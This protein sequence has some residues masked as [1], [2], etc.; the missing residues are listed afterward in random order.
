MNCPSCGAANPDD[1]QACSACGAAASV[2]ALGPGFLLASRY[3][4]LKV[5]GRGGMGMVYQARDRLLDE[6]VAIKVLRPDAA[7]TPE[8]ARRFRA[9]IK[10]ARSVSHKNVGRIHEY[11][12]DRGIRYISMAFVDGVD[13]KQVLR[14]RGPLPPAEAF[15][16]LLRVADALQ[17]I[18][19]EGIIHRDLKA[20]NVML[21]RRGVV[22]LMDFGIAKQHDDE[23][24]S[25]TATGQIIGTPEYMSPEQVQ[26]L[27]LDCRSDVYSLGVVAFELF[28]G[29]T[30]FRADTPLGTVLK[31]LNE[32]PPLE[33]EQAARLPPAL[34]PV[35][36][37]ALAKKR[38]DR[39]SSAREMAQALEEA[40]AL[41]TDT[42]HR[43]AKT[44]KGPYFPGQGETL[45]P[46]LDQG[47]KAPTGERAAHAEAT[48]LL[49]GPSR[50]RRRA[51]LAGG[52]GA[53]LV[54]ATWALLRPT[55][56]AATAPA[57]PVVSSPAPPSPLPP[58]PS[59]AA[60]PAPSVALDPPPGG[61]PRVAVRPEPTPVHPVGGA[62]AAPP[63]VDPG[64]ASPPAG[65]ARVDRLLAEA[66]RAL[67]AESFD[68]A[69]ARY[70]EVLAVDARN[71]VARMGRTAAVSA[72]VARA[73]AR[74]PAVRS[75]VAEKTRAESA[76]TRPDTALASAFEEAPGIAVTR[77]SQTAALPG[78]IEFKTDP[79]AVRAGEKYKLEVRFANTGTAPIGIAAMLVTTTVNGRNA[80]G[81][82]APSVSTVAPG[83]T[84]PVLSLSDTLREDL[85]SWSLEVQV[86]TTRGE[87]YRNRLAWSDPD[88]LKP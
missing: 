85:K 10:I 5:L 19:D 48:R 83:Q 50:W 53:V 16:I 40:R 43:L 9:E 45:V 46:T 31:H 25:M 28:T 21:D 84:A 70:D 6:T 38:E 65:D 32:P 68:A 87:T 44:V 88:A 49:A 24:L 81:P 7:A 22:R 1:A 27:R 30:P 51:A 61:R 54:A 80:G 34:V 37:K 57:P 11:G 4:I 23:G 42:T 47:L 26:A 86:R 79:E 18:H 74:A 20:P 75:F 58:A 36:R 17:A 77:D 41:T 56:P 63:L 78:R 3:E 12:E 8:I 14:E 29:T 73:P 60:T 13:L 67:E 64:A 35:L 33:G 52:A 39:Y 69:I 72:K 62:A 82:V 71:A 55:P 76:E 66:E 15:E 2:P 59:A